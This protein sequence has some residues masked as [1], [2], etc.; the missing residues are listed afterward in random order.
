MSIPDV[1]E[2]RLGDMVFNRRGSFPRRL[3]HAVVSIALRLF[4]RRIETLN[5]SEVPYRG[6]LIFVLNHPNGLID[7]SLVFV[8]LPRK[9]SFLAKSTLFRVP[10]LSYLLKLAEAL[11]VYRRIDE[12]DLEQNAKTFRASG[13]LLGKGGAIALF[14]EG[15]SHNSPQLLPIKTGAAR[16]ALSAASSISEREETVNILPCGIYY[17]SKTRFRSEALIYFGKPFPVEVSEPDEDGEPARSEVRRLTRRISHAMKQVTVNAE[18]V[19]DIESANEAANL[20]LSVTET[21][22]L[23]EPLAARFEFV[24]S[25]LEAAPDDAESVRKSDDVTRLISNYK[26][27]LRMIGLEPENLSLSKHPY[28]Y[29]FQHFVRRLLFLIVILP[30][31][32]AGILIHFPAYRMAGML[33]RRYQKHGADDIVS[34]VKIIAGIVLMPLSWIITGLIVGYFFGP[35]GFFIAVP[36]AAICGYA[37]MRTMETLA[38][39]TGWFRAVV[40]FFRRRDLFLQLILERRELHR[41]L[42]NRN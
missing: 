20:F 40:L 4:F 34:T 14:P 13:K 35:A 1:K 27:K 9:V 38:D 15:V 33:G 37:A 7:P 26:K 41:R 8:A 23:E 3:I 21:L 25:Y 17:S 32:L 28:W 11:P 16:I 19:S 6:P 24:R 30:L 42:V 12:A 18:T 22:D 36:A 5:A 2:L 29:V 10:G 39:L 31:S